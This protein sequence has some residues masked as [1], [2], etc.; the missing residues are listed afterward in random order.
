MYGS[1]IYNYLYNQCLSHLK[2]WV[3]ISLR[4]GVL[5]TLCDKDC[6]Q[7]VAGRRFST[8]AP[9]SSTYKTDCHDITEILL[10]VVLLQRRKCPLM[11]KEETPQCSAQIISFS[12]CLDQFWN[13]LFPNILLKKKRKSA[14][15]KKTFIYTLNIIN[16]IPQS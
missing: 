1:W 11:K 12:S 6:Q 9:V 15:Q 10:K 3:R 7:T 16:L 2:L 5:D 13:I 4:R 8:G 14:D